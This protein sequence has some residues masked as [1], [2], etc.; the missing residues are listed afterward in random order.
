VKRSDDTGRPSGPSPVRMR[1]PKCQAFEGIPFRVSTVAG[2]P[3]DTRVEFRCQTCQHEWA[4]EVPAR[5]NS[6]PWGS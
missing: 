6:S 4:V 5:A 2:Q 1:C 3:A